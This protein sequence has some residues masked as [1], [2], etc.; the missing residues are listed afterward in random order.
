MSDLDSVRVCCMLDEIA[1]ARACDAHN[2]NGSDT[3]H[4]VACSRIMALHFELRVLVQRCN[5]PARCWVVIRRFSTRSLMVYLCV[6]TERS[7]L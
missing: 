3:S 2:G 1:F 7:E 4:F 6:G 5:N